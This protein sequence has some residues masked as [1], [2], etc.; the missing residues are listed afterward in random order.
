MALELQKRFRVRRSANKK[1][2]FNSDFATLDHEDNL[3]E[4]FSPCHTR[5]GTLYKPGERSR[6][7][8]DSEDSLFEEELQP[9][10]GFEP[11]GLLS[12][13]AR[14]KAEPA[15]PCFLRRRPRTSTVVPPCSPPTPSL[16][17]S[18]KRQHSSSSLSSSGISDCDSDDSGRCSPELPGKKQRVVSEEESS[19]YE[20]EFLELGELASGQYGSVRL[21]RH[22]LDG[23]EYAIKVNKEALRPGSYQEKRALNEVAA[24]ARLNE[25]PHV[26]QY[27]N[28]WRE[29]G[30]VYIL[31]EFCDGGSF[32]QEIGRRRE[33]GQHYSEAELRTVLVHGLRGLRYIHSCGMTHLDIKPDNILVSRAENGGSGPAEVSSDSGAESDDPSG[34]LSRMEIRGEAGGNTYKLGDLGHAAL[35]E[36]ITDPEEGDCRYMAPELFR[37]SPEKALLP[38]AD[39]FSL[40][41]SVWEAASL[42]SLPRNSFDSPLYSELRTGRLP[43]LPRYSARFNSWL[44][45]LVR[46]DPAARSSAASLLRVI[47]R[48]SHSSLCNEVQQARERLET[49]TAALHTKQ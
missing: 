21:V 16:R 43:Y 26:V 18:F 1:L 14:H 20:R 44:S 3:T 25:D 28:S 47:S 11:A 15:S 5:S 48:Q 2:D 6:N 10:E 32:S 8:S 30:R 9:L 24:H 49:L 36:R 4:S 7:S 17:R 13:I 37:I 39:L 12:P 31:T 33:A 45:D 34:L 27:Y 40:G 35:L 19:R 29:A 23:T 41:L 22:R 46:P 42:T 38:A